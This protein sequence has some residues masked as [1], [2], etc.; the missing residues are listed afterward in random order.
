MIS[1]FSE[2]C[3]VDF[4]D[5]FGQSVDVVCQADSGDWRKAQARLEHSA[6][7]FLQNIQQDYSNIKT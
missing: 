1:A 5:A 3:A 2:V 6:V 7:C 4:G